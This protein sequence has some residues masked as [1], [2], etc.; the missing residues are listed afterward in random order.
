MPTSKISAMPTYHYRCDSCKHEF[1]AIQKMMDEPLTQ[2]Q[3]CTGAVHRLI[4][5]GVGISFK[6]EGFHINDYSGKG[7]ASAPAATPASESKK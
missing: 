7:A 5:G 6:G 3:V 4:S 1:D 2:C